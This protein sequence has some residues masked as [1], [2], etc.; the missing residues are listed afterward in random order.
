MA[1]ESNGGLLFSI[2]LDNSQ[3]QSDIAAAQRMFD[4]LKQGSNINIGSMFGDS[5]NEAAD[6]ANKYRKS[7][8]DLYVA[9]GNAGAKVRDESAQTVTSVSDDLNKLNQGFNAITSLAGKM[10][11]GV[12]AMEIGNKMLETRSYFQDAESSMRVFLGSAEK[13]TKFINELKDYAYNNMFEFSDLVGASKQLIAYGT[14]AEDVTDVLDRLSNIATGTGANL[15]DMIGLYNKAKS[16]GKVDAMGL[17]SWAAKGVLVKDTLRDMGE[18]VGSTGVT[19]NQLE[20]V[21]QKV[22]GEGGMFHDLM[23]EQMDNLSASIGQLEDNLTSMYNE[24][25]EASEG[26]MKGAIDIAGLLVENYQEIGSVLLEVAKIYGAYK[27]VDMSGIQEI[28]EQSKAE[29]ALV[30]TF[31]QHG[32]ELHKLLSSEQQQELAMQ[33]L[34]EGTLEYAKAVQDMIVGEK[35]RSETLLKN[36]ESELASETTRKAKLEELMAATEEEIKLAEK[37][38]DAKKLEALQNGK[39]AL[40][41]EVATSA[42][43]VAELQGKK[44]I[45]TISASIAAKKAETLATAQNTTATTKNT[46][47]KQ[48][49][50]K[51]SA[52]LGKA[53]NGLNKVLNET[54]LA[55]PYAL[56]LAGAVALGSAI[57]DIITAETERDK[58]QKIIDEETAK[59]FEKT[60]KELEDSV[61]PIFNRFRNLTEGTED[62]KQAL[63]D[64]IKQYPELADVLGDEATKTEILTKGYD[65]V[66]ESILKKN[67]A[68]AQSEGV[69]KAKDEVKELQKT[70]I[71]DFNEA[72]ED[73]DYSSLDASHLRVEFEKALTD[74]LSFD[75]MSEELQEV[76]TKSESTLKKVLSVATTGFSDVILA[77]KY[78]NQKGW[79][80]AM[81]TRLTNP[82]EYEEY[83]SAL[84]ASFEQ[85]RKYKGAVDETA[86]SVKELTEEIVISTQEEDKFWNSGWEKAQKDQ[87]TAITDQLGGVTLFEYQ[88]LGWSKVFKDKIKQ[89]QKERNQQQKKLRKMQKEIYG[90]DY[91]TQQ[92]KYKKSIDQ[93]K[94]FAAE[95]TKLEIKRQED[96][97]KLNDNRDKQGANN[98]VID[99]QIE[100]VNKKADDQ[101]AL[102]YAKYYNVSQQTAE[103]VKSTF[104]NALSMPVDE[105]KQRLLEITKRL[106]QIKNASGNGD[107]IATREEQARLA[108]EQAGL[109]QNI[110]TAEEKKDFSEKQK[111]YEAYYSA[112]VNMQTEKETKIAEL[113]DKLN[114]KI[115]NEDQFNQAIKN[116]EDYTETQANIIQHS[117]G[118]TDEELY[119]QTLDRIGSATD[120]GARELISTIEKLQG[121]IDELQGHLEDGLDVSEDLAKVRKEYNDTV[122]E[123]KLLSKSGI[124][125]AEQ[126]LIDAQEELQ[127]LEE[128]SAK[129][130]DVSKQ[131]ALQK[132]VIEQYKKSIEE[133]RN[134]QI[135]AEE[136]TKEL[137]ENEIK[138]EQALADKA[139][140]DKAVKAYK[141][142]SD[143][144]KNILDVMDGVSDETKETINTMI[145]LGSTAFDLVGQLYD[146]AVTTS[147]AV[148]VEGEASAEAVKTAERGSVILAVIGA[149]IQAVMAII[150]IFNKHGKT[151]QAEKNIQR[152]EGQVKDLDRAYEKLGDRIDNAYAT[153]A[154][155][156][157]QQQD[158]LLEQKEA[159]LRQEIAEEKSKKKKKQDADAIK[160]LEQQ[161]EDLAETRA[162]TQQTMVE[163]LIGK[164]Y[165]GVLEDFSGAVMD[166]MDDAETS[167][168]DAVKNIGNTIKKSAIQQQL[169]KK[170]QQPSE[171]YAKAMAKAMEDGVLSASEKSV[172]S[173]LENS[174]A[175]ISENYLGQFDDLWAKAEA[176]ERSAVSGGIASI[177]QDTAEEMNGRLTQIQSHTFS[178]SAN[179]AEMKSFAERQLVQLQA[180]NSNT[181]QALTNHNNML[182]ILGEF[183]TKGVKMR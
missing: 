94:S 119:T 38:G 116:L 51:A 48:L 53:A 34:K 72:L 130:E 144:L 17:E 179:V 103:Q 93:Y 120:L 147:K 174:I 140:W 157:I 168:Q 96:I 138:L 85:M 109:Q 156:L 122:E 181:L 123:L 80:A 175:S 110:K 167:V 163:A 69:A 36:T 134:A 127:K 159:L 3:L 166:A 71:E 14:A 46:I 54:L 68:I 56:A 58:V 142:A 91:N 66:R 151:A 33:G 90:D 49:A 180:I 178:I 132:Q 162:N 176:E 61:D 106:E 24:M 37:S 5:G 19:F 6:V 98:A 135:T 73:A 113:N 41:E 158:K 117:L 32:E 40:S 141:S 136:S 8:Q 59:G 124:K 60:T 44:E 161:L 148:V 18:V 143:G 89:L 70:L 28:L 164:D 84:R 11:L 55:N 131:I 4:T 104:S 50:A 108:A 79:G 31:Q 169:M 145:D 171:E 81:Q 42:K 10:F 2:R 26:V 165:K 173:G 47:A 7:L 86:E 29:A 74:G 9:A 152:I 112:L 39:V 65:A 100:D 102:L 105:A 67:D 97:K 21:L 155:D 115:I 12:S 129:G 172:L 23:M 63:A 45:A 95:Y 92:Q 170:L 121:E 114:K 107:N 57:Y 126:G 137:T 177:S 88:W 35:E 183:Q 16:V 20:K 150:K 13:G 153:D 149:A 99:V 52:A 30:E 62:Y 27:L 43:K 128:R 75:E 1:E 83:D 139:K 125:I 133:Y 146:Y 77:G 22:T 182:A 76:F 64:L 160:E 78:S 87:I 118:L 111:K 154:T 15:N 82:L 25:G 101:L